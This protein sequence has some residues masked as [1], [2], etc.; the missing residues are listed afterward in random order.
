MKIT[1]NQI[2]SG[3]RHLSGMIDG[4]TP[5][6]DNMYIGSPCK[7]CGDGNVMRYIKHDL[8]V[9]CN[10]T[11]SAIIKRGQFEKHDRRKLDDYLLEKELYI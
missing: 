11:R 7:N 1:T 10:K 8:C 3:K 2:L 5:I 6:P 9:K 4:T